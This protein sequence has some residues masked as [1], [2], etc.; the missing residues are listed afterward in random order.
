M[1]RSP[2]ISKATLNVTCM[3]DLLNNI[4]TCQWIFILHG[5][6]DSVARLATA[7]QRQRFGQGNSSSILTKE[8]HCEGNEEHL[9]DCTQGSSYPSEETN[10]KHHACF[11]WEDAGVICTGTVYIIICMYSY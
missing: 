9:L 5:T 7:T 1:I 6:S 8:I 2:N 10:L 4:E 11:H 3:H